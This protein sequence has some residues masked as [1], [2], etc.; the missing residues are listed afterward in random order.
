MSNKTNPPTLAEIMKA[1]LGDLFAD[2]PESP[3][4][5][6]SSN[7]YFASGVAFGH[8]WHV[9]RMCD[10]WG[11]DA[12]K[13]GASDHAVSFASGEECASKGDAIQAALTAIG[14]QL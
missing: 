3:Q 5:A 7:S 12:W 6:E 13:P 8:D 10:E 2:A 9:V 4:Q 11:W 14:E 1:Q